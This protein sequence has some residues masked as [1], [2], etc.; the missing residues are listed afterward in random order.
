[1]EKQAELGHDK[2]FGAFWG[3]TESIG[4]KAGS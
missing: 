1:M 3:G 2:E 4:E